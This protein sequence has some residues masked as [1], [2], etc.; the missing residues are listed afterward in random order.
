MIRFSWSLS[1]LCRKIIIIY[2]SIIFKVSPPPIYKF[3]N[4]D[5]LNSHRVND[6]D[7]IL[8][9]HTYRRISISNRII[10]RTRF[11]PS[12]FNGNETPAP[13]TMSKHQTVSQTPLFARD[14]LENRQCTHTHTHTHHS[15]FDKVHGRI[16]DPIETS[17]DALFA[18]T[19]RDVP[20]G[21][22]SFLLKYSERLMYHSLP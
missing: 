5:L 3:T 10:I 13:S 19:K 18:Q 11:L 14:S 6:D 15:W 7:I 16:C 17:D 22:R 12:D 9:L 2:Q 1:N 4:S 20:I 8:T 21:N